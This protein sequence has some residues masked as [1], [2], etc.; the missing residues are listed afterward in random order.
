[1][2]QSDAL[3]VLDRALGVS[4]RNGALKHLTIATSD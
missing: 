1:L 4:R 3:Q 2:L